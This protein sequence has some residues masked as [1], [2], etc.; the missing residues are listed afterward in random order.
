MLIVYRDQSHKT[1]KKVKQAVSWFKKHLIVVHL[2]V[3]SD[4][5]KNNV[6]YDKKK[7]DFVLVLGGDGTYLRTVHFIARYSVPFLGINIGSLGFLT[8]HRQELM[9]HCLDLVLKNQIMIEKRT[10]IEVSLYKENKLLHQYL[11]L[12]DIVIERGSFSHL[13]SVSIDI[14]K[15]KIYALKADGL[16]V[17]S[18]T[19]STAYN[20]AGGGPILHPFVNALAVTPICS[21]SLTHRPVIVPDDFLISLRINNNTQHAFLTVDGEKKAPI[22]KKHFMTICKSR[23]KHKS[24]K[25]KNYNHFSLLKDKLNFSK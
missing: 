25:L 9:E 1:L 18:P 2:M 19:G 6:N 8:V 10:L 3:Q 23:V 15:Q 20:L 22:S 12:N 13:I 4:L 17:S 24:F 21:H 5:L 14:Q 7:I 11:A 16:I